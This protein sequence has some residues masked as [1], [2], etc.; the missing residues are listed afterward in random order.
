[1]WVFRA[2][3]DEVGGELDFSVFQVDG[4][5]Q[6]DD[7]MVVRVGDGEREVDASG[8][9]L[10]RSGSAELFAVED[11]GTGGDFYTEDARVAGVE[12]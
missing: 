11:I 12:R 4:I 9:A 8:D 6:V 7:A 5:A 3:G 2:D 1:M 10:V